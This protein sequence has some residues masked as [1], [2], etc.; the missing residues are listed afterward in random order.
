LEG[1][2]SIFIWHP[3]QKQHGETAFS[4]DDHRWNHTISPLMMSIEEDGLQ[5]A[6]EGHRSTEESSSMML[7]A[8]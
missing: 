4:Q 7:I 2:L 3:K 8:F 1:A 5:K 6:A